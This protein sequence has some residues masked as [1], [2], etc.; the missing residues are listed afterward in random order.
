MRLQ[1]SYER[2]NPILLVRYQDRYWREFKLS[3]RQHEKEF[4][5]N[6]LIR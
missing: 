3:I 2:N 6:G 4:E 5:M 1:H